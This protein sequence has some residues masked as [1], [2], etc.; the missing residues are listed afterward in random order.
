MAAGI[1][2]ATALTLTTTACGGGSTTAGSDSS[3]KTLTYWASN[4]GTSLDNDKQVL[5]PELKKFEQQT[6]IKVDLEV[7]PWSD[8]LNRILAATASG[9]GPDVLNI[10]NTW[11]ASL[12]ATG[13]L[14]PFDQAAFARIGGKDR[15]LPAAVAS[16]GAV[17]KDPA[18]VPLYSMAYG[19]YYDKTL[20]QAAG[21]ANPPT[22]WDELVA[23]G[24]KLTTGSQYGLAIEG[25]N[26]SE[27]VHN[28]FML[29]L[30]HGTGFY[31]TSGKPQFDSP[32]A[33][34][35]VKQYVD[36]IAADKIAAPGDAEYAANQSVTDFATG[37]AAMLMWQ[38]AGPSLKS[39]GMNPDD[40]GVASIPV[41]AGATGSQ[42]TTS[43]VAGIN[44]AVFKNTHNLD[45]ALDFV[46]FMTGDDE[47]KILNSSYGSLP[48]VRSVEA[49]PAFA[50]P[51]L[52]TLAGVLQNS[53]APLPQVASE[54]QFETL[55]GTAVKNLLAAAAAGQ[56]VTDATVKSELTKAQ[57]QMPAG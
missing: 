22:T 49:D 57:Q 44:L 40:Y 32:Q 33:V 41:P 23:D 5:E 53:A 27:N 38:A 46:K 2:L 1:A 47:Q 26:V 11:S 29:G 6:G 52:K 30:Q 14:L 24:K 20:F 7:I 36:F 34:A 9:Q 43:M 16:A 37:K 17:G 55:V 28:A 12:Q 8:L 42:A 39:H 35:A 51:E 10:G 56:P 54:S 48:P 13:A 3:P 31:D 18:A 21:I 25:G 15:F 4:Q 19:L 45:G 50:T